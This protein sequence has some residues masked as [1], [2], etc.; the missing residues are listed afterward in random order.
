MSE[1]KRRPP[2]A[3]PDLMPS[4][5]LLQISPA[6]DARSKAIIAANLSPKR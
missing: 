5:D 2:P 4:Q 6:A 1:L 3:L